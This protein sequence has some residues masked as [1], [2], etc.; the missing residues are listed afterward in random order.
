MQF[1]I[2]RGCQR[3]GQDGGYKSSPGDNSYVDTQELGEKIFLA[4]VDSEGASRTGSLGSLF[5]RGSGMARRL[6][7]NGRQAQL[8]RRD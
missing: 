1:G 4:P 6:E 3:A 5:L 8:R 7:G 2:D